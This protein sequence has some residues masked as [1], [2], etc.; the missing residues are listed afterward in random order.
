MHT[1]AYTYA[2]VIL[3]YH[4]IST[5]SSVS[6]CAHLT[7]TVWDF[8]SD[9]CIIGNG[10]HGHLIR[11]W[12]NISLDAFKKNYRSGQ[13]TGTDIFQ[14]EITRLSLKCIAIVFL[15]ISLENETQPM[16]KA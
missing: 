2:A 15:K 7:K 12:Y 16:Q 4:D 14:Y 5:E 10:Y 3:K 13:D 6:A 11:V 1:H 9:L 8:F